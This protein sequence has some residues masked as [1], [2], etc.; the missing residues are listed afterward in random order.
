MEQIY[1][2][3]VKLHN[4]LVSSCISID[5]IKLHNLTNLLTCY[6]NYE[7]YLM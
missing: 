2:Q 3:N 1:F 6:F 4:Y 5:F 7:S